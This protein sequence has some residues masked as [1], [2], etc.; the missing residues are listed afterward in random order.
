ML[1]SILAAAVVASLATAASA[2]DAA[3]PIKALYLT[4]G[5][6]HDYKKLT[7][8]L[9]EGMAKHANIDWTVKWGVEPLKDAKF[10]DPF[11]VVVYN[12]CFS[13]EKDKDLI[14]NAVRA[15]RDGKPTVLV[16]CS[17]HCFMASDEW[18]NC[19]G[20]R[21]RRHDGYRGFSTKK[22]DSKHPIVQAWPDDWKTAGDEL[23]QNIAF[24]ETSKPLLTAYSVESKTDH[25]VAWTH[26]FGR[27]PVFGTTLGH[28][29]NTA[30]QDDY[31]RLLANGV[32][33]AT[34]KLED[35]GK[36]KPGYEGKKGAESSAP[37]K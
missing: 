8:L 27:G 28:D 12:F 23:Y 14:E 18:T 1:R 31:H 22:P 5:G 34:D 13:D 11:D 24:P 26:Q 20:L 17:M 10:A 36:P 30:E 37:G 2:E 4:G 15:T 29:M 16:H 32:L 33:W 21:T 3:A 9:T 7:P 25:V 6:Y 35:D 19:C